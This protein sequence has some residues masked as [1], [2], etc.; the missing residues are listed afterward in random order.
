MAHLGLGQGGLFFFFTRRVARLWA[1]LWELAFLL[2]LNLG[3]VPEWGEIPFLPKEDKMSIKKLKLNEVGDA[4]IF[5]TD[6]RGL[7]TL[8]VEE[9]ALLAEVPSNLAFDAILVS[10]PKMGFMRA[11]PQAWCWDADKSFGIHFGYLALVSDYVDWR[12][13]I[14]WTSRPPIPPT[15]R[16]LISEA[17][18]LTDPSPCEW[19]SEGRF[20][21]EGCDEGGDVEGDDFE[22]CGPFK[23]EAEAIEAASNAD[24]CTVW[25]V[26]L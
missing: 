15:I 1:K 7:V 12:N 20:H 14:R 24:D 13:E 16:P 19:W 23:S 25:C 10:G 2:V 11:N 26:A 5:L 21:W 4:V 22:L 18:I 8:Y 17:E 3:S 6:N 9:L